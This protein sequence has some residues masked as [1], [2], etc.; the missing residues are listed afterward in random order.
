MDLHGPSLCKLSTVAMCR[1]SFKKCES[2]RIAR[3]CSVDCQKNNWRH[4][5]KFRLCG[6]CCVSHASGFCDRTKHDVEE[7][8]I[9]R[10]RENEI[11]RQRDKDMEPERERQR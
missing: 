10:E 3:Y 1:E 11:D 6:I 9:D 2:C 4:G 5:G 8:E 7:G